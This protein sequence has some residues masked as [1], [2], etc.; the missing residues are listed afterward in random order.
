MSELRKGDKVETTVELAGIPAG[1]RGTI[2]DEHGAVT[3]E[4]V[5]VKLTSGGSL[6]YLTSELKRV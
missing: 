6:F 3:P 4:R 1:A 2:A 5:E